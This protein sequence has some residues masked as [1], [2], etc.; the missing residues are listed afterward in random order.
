MLPSGKGEEFN[1][2]LLQPLVILYGNQSEIDP[3]SYTL[4]AMAPGSSSSSNSA[5]IVL[6]PMVEK[7]GKNNQSTW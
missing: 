3:I 2:I 6:Q 4:A 5:P 1:P 7:L